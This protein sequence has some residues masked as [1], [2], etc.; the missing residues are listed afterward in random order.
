MKRLIAI[1]VVAISM[2]TASAQRA[3]DMGIFSGSNDDWN[4]SSMFVETHL[5]AVVGDVSSTGFGWGV[6]LGFRLH[7]I[8]G[9]CWDVV[10]VGMNT[11]VLNFVDMLDVRFLSGLRYNSPRF[12]ADKSLYLNFALGYH[13]FTECT[14]YS[15]F[16]YEVGGGINLSRNLSMGITWEAS[17]TTAEEYFFGDYYDVKLNWGTVGLKLAYQF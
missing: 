11:D 6:G 1:L 7:L 15:G 12:I 3:A 2:A 14:T 16:A 17:H 13:L 10:K 9:L 5:G 4:H 8:D